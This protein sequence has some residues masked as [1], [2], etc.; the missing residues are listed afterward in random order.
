MK[1]LNTNRFSLPGTHNRF[2]HI[3]TVQDG[4]SEFM[5]FFDGLEKKMYIERITASS[6]EFIED[7]K[8]AQDLNDFLMDN[9]V[10]DLRYGEMVPD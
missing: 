10:I 4:L 2:V 1:L 7:D 9:H 3:A 8:L 6:L 5:C